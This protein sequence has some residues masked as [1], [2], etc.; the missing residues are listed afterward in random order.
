MRGSVGRVRRDDRGGGVVQLP[1][2]ATVFIVFASLMVFVGR[3]NSGSAVAEAGARYAARTMSLA[4]DPRAA[5]DEAKADAET[6][7][8]VGSPSCRTMSFDYALEAAQVT[9][10]ITCTVELVGLG[11]PANWSV[12]GRAEEPIDRLREASGP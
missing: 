6:T 1:L 12:T 10:S 9:V 7:V 4:R 11:V 3:V 2:M 5:A 8:S